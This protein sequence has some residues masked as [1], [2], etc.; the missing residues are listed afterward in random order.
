MPESKDIAIVI[1]A[2]G[3]G[4][5]LWPLSQP[6]YPK[7]LLK[8]TGEMTLIQNTYQRAKLVTDNIYVVTEQSHAG[9]VAK[10]L[11][12]MGAHQLI[13]E[14]GR[15][16][17]A[18][19]IVLSLAH[20]KRQGMVG[21]VVFIHADH[22]ITDELG[23]ALGVRV[24]TAAAANQ[25]LISLVGI[26]PTHPA[27]GFGYIEFG[28]QIDVDLGLPVYKVSSFKE[29]PA[30]QVATK[31]LAAGNY[32]WNQGLFA[33][34]L[35]VWVREFKAYDREYYI[36]YEALVAA[37][38][39][40]DQLKEI[41]LAL[42]NDAIDYALM[43]KSPD[44]IVVP[45]TYDWADIGSFF[46]LHQ[47]TQGDDGN[48]VSGKVMTIDCQ[49][50]MIQG[51]TKPIIAIGLDG[52]IVVDTPEGLLVCAKTESQ[53]VGDAVKELIKQGEASQR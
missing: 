22:H 36:G 38:N 41:Y 8:L 35:N 45:G 50:S 43:E 10:Q 30:L 4:T 34:P 14:P 9:E 5:R 23:F 47:L 11:P 42:R 53:K 12:D 31:Y 6:N 39:N 28:Q 37:G 18:S 26:T 3:S 27:T 52:I 33:A 17:T 24:A 16:G 19:C 32:L 15:R 20:L 49:D 51:D 48:S 44:L 29:K 7:H 21:N 1:I 40:N 25:Q 13:V 46:D 2:G